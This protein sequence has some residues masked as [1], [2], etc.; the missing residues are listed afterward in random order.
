MREPV[1]TLYRPV[2]RAELELI[3]AA[4]FA[5]FPPRLPRQ[6]Y[7]YPV[8]SEDYA[9]EIARDWNTK[10]EASG[11]EG[12]VLKFVVRTSF[13]S[14]YEVHKVGSSRHREYWIPA[15]DLERFN[16]SIVGR[17]EVIRNFP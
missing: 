16:A 12:Y 10:D 8:L 1:T 13:L 17:I 14:N 5:A 3:R 2:G 4:R 6:P 9:V 15:A 11:Y 7:F